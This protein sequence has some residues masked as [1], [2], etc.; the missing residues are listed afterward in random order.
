M[1]D[2]FDSRFERQVGKKRR[3][4]FQTRCRIIEL[5]F[6]SYGGQYIYGIKRVFEIA[7]ALGLRHDVVSYTI[8]RYVKNGGFLMAHPELMPHNRGKVKV[9]K[10]VID[11]ITDPTVLRS[12][13]HLNLSDRCDLIDHE[14]GIRIRHQTLGWWY[15]RNG[16]TWTKPQLKFLGAKKRPNLLKEQAEWCHQL[17]E[18][19]RRGHEIVWIDE[20]TTNLWDQRGRV[21]QH[22]GNPLTVHRP[23]DRGKSTTVYG[24]LFRHGGHLRFH[25]GPSTNKEDFLVFLK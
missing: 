14:F 11:H 5:R 4:N 17:T 21:W 3:L 8:R 24:A 16:I 2:E 25:F 9:T 18:Y 1:E 22:K 15:R 19:H 23:S 20:T 13:A 10:E 12:W 7:K 6:G